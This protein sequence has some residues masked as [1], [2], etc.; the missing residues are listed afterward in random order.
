MDKNSS[1]RKIDQSQPFKYELL[2]K[3]FS[4]AKISDSDEV[5]LQNQF[6]QRF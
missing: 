3:T 6:P 5:T 2:T 1:G 4:Q